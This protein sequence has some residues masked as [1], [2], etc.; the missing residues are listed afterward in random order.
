M[1]ARFGKRESCFR[2]SIYVD[3][4]A[5]VIKYLTWLKL[6]FIM[7][8]KIKIYIKLNKNKNYYGGLYILKILYENAYFYFK[9]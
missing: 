8:L 7:I 9:K 1:W 2:F 6:I 5:H 4:R 3:P